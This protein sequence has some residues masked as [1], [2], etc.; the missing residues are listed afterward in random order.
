MAALPGAKPA[1]A[2]TCPAPSQAFPLQEARKV[3]RGTAGGISLAQGWVSHGV[4]G[5]PCPGHQRGYALS[6]RQNAWGGGKRLCQAACSWLC[7]G[8]SRNPGEFLTCLTGRDD[9]APEPLSA[10]PPLHGI[11]GRVRPSVL[12]GTGHTAAPAHSPPPDAT[13]LQKATEGPQ[14]LRWGI[15]ARHMRVLVW[16]AAC[17][18]LG[19]SPRRDTAG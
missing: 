11:L 7:P 14:S 17:G 16:G 6:R 18:R 3:P 5:R 19:H 13:D 15:A 4:W 2:G 9:S 8:M 10:P 1:P 12:C